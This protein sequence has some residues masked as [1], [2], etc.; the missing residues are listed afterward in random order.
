MKCFVTIDSGLI[1]KEDIVTLNAQSKEIQYDFIE[2][3]SFFPSEVILILIDLVQN[4]GYSAAYD[5]LKYILL[6][7]VSLVVNKRGSNANLQFEISCNNKRFSLKGKNALTE[8]Q[9]DKLV[10]AAVKALL[11]EW[12]YKE[13]S[14]EKQ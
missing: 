12:S 7:V 1:N 9:M 13:N 3:N 4:I 8:Q 14:N 5:T 6:K 11:S 10:D 2:G